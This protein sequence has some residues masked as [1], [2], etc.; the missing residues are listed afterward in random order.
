MGFGDVAS[1]VIMFISIVTISLAFV[2]MLNDMNQSTQSALSSKQKIENDKLM[3][4]LS[5]DLI[6]YRNGNLNIYI[7]NIGETKIKLETISF[8]LDGEFLSNETITKE[9]IS[10]T[11]INDIGIFNK[12]EILKINLSKNL[13]IGEHTII[14]SLS[15]GYVKSETFYS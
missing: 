9:I 6:D 10:E 11:D 4:S 12:N 5:F 13:D 14:L 8:Y 15:N 3:S 2:F 7:K 1:Q